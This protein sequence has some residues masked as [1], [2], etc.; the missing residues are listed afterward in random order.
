[1][2]QSHQRVIYS[3]KAYG[4][5]VGN[6][7]V[8]ESKACPSLEEMKKLPNKVLL[9]CAHEVPTCQGTSIKVFYQQYAL[10]LFQDTWKIQDVCRKLIY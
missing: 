2:Q 10:L 7:F 4:V 6:F 1:M 9:W 3:L 8:V 5:S